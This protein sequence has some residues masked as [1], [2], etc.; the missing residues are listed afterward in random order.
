MDLPFDTIYRFSYSPLLCPSVSAGRPGPYQNIDAANPHRHVLAWGKYTQPKTFLPLLI[1]PE[2]ASRMAH[3]HHTLE[4]V[5]A[6][7]E[8]LESKY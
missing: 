6:T 2:D 4:S 7:K 3:R 5:Y 1:F 8:A